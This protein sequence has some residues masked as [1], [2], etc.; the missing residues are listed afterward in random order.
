MPEDLIALVTK[1]PVVRLDAVD[2]HVGYR[3]EEGWYTCLDINIQL[4]K[5]YHARGY[6]IAVISHAQPG[7][8]S[9]S[10]IK[11]DHP[12]MGLR[13]G[14]LVVLLHTDKYT[15]HR[16]L[17]SDFT[18]FSSGGYIHGR[19]YDHL[20]L[21]D[22]ACHT[23]L[24]VRPSQVQVLT[25]ETVVVGSVAQEIQRTLRDQGPVAVRKLYF[26]EE[27]AERPKGM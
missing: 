17:D 20:A 3:I 8:R 15:T 2:V 5:P 10:E 11:R 27:I 12:F 22:A 18:V 4:A 9:E 26:E 13:K 23:H 19:D 25:P 1:E 21:E 6:R 14:D 7:C 16:S 24:E